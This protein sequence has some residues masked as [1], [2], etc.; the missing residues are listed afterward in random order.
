MSVQEL[1]VASERLPQRTEERRRAAR[2]ARLLSWFSL[3]WMGAEGAVAITAGILAGS[4]ALIGF[5]IDSAIEGF[6]SLVIVWRFT[7]SRLL[8]ETS[9][10]RAQKLVAVQFF[11]LAPYVGG[12][13]VSKLVSGEHPKTSWLGVA[14]TASSL[15]VMPILGVAKRRLAVQL[16]SIATQGEGMQNILCA[17]LAGAVLIGLLGNTLFGL[18]WLDPLAAMVIAAVAVREGLESWRGN[19]CC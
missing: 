8:S 15:L 3:A 9:E 19:E 1:N 16:G 10:R 6:A 13:A 7:G 12:E 18:W 14:L 11:L 17:Y 5:G 2:R 4:I